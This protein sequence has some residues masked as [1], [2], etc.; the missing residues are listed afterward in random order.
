MSP[1]VTRLGDGLAL[2]SLGD[3]GSG[4]ALPLEWELCAGSPSAAAAGAPSGASLLQCRPA[5]GAGASTSS[6]R[7]AAS[8]GAPVVRRVG[9]M[10]G[11]AL[12]QVRGSF[13]MGSSANFG[14]PRL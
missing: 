6:W 5:S 3:G 12:F 11:G 7:Q 10:R 4:A 1:G 9:D 2:L 14:R 13:L 8:R